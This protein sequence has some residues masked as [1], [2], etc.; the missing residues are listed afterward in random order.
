MCAQGPGES[1]ARWP[2]RPRVVAAGIASVMLLAGCGARIPG[3]G[4][5]APTGSRTPPRYA[6]CRPGDLAPQRILVAPMG[7]S[8]VAFR[9]RLANRGAP[10]SLRGYPENFTGITVTGHRHSI[11]VRPDSAE[12]QQALTSG[13]AADLAT[14]DLVELVLHA[15]YACVHP[16][17]GDQSAQIYRRIRFRFPRAHGRIT[18]DFTPRTDPK[19]DGMWLP[20]CS[21]FVS[22]FYAAIDLTEYDAG[23]PP[24]A[25]PT[26]IPRCGKLGMRYSHATPTGADGD[27]AGAVF[28]LRNLG[29][30]CRIGGY[31]SAR[32][33]FVHGMRLPSVTPAAGA[34]RRRFSSKSLPLRRRPVPQLVIPAQGRA[35]FEVHWTP[36]TV[37]RCWGGSAAF[38]VVDVRLPGVPG[39]QGPVVPPGLTACKGDDVYTTPVVKHLGAA[40]RPR[41]RR[42]AATRSR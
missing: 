10:C 42:A 27:T 22:R 25:T 40:P 15:G 1:C 29:R 16:Q 14:G 5:A 13:R 30:T 36:G 18:V 7:M 33:V 20:D 23:P 37:G 6:A 31:P 35:R 24:A 39:V 19:M 11:R 41:R 12:S 8:Q 38:R 3:A 28:T 2:P 21:T 34:L 9:V 4:P 17:G 26:G 32:L